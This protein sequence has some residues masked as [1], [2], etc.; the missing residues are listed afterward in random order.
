MATLGAEFDNVDNIDPEGVGFEYGG[1]LTQSECFRSRWYAAHQL[2]LAR[3]DLEDD[4]RPH[5]RP[6][7]KRGA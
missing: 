3:F 1:L 5:E 6:V 4:A 2:L 7:D